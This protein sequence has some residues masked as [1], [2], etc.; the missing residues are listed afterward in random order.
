MNNEFDTQY[1]E[2]TDRRSVLSIAKNVL[3][4]S[5]SLKYLHGNFFIVDIVLFRNA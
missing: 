2:D 4:I 1:K 5:T 3:P